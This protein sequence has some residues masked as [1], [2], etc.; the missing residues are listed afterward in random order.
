MNPLRRLTMLGGMALLGGQAIGEGATH[1]V[2]SPRATTRAASRH[3]QVQHRLQ[4][5]LAHPAF[6]GHAHLLMPGGGVSYDEAMPLR[7]IGDLLPYHTNVRPPEVVDALNRM[8][9]NVA[10]G[11]VVFHDIYT[12]ADKQRDPARGKTGLF[13]FRGKPGAPFAVVAPGGG[14][15]YV[16]SVHEGF[17]YAME[18]SNKGYNAFVLVYR[19][20]QGGAVAT[21]DL[22]AALSFI[23]RNA[24]RLGVNTRAYSLWGSSAGARMAAAIGTHGAAAFGGDLLPK[25]AAVVMAYTGHDEFSPQDPPTFALVGENDR[26]APPEVME[27]R[28][29]ALRNAGVNVA[30]R[31]YPGVAH[32][33]GR[34]TGTSAS[35]WVGDAIGFWERNQGR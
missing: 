34:G 19:V 22:A 30:W 8:I 31:R 15:S 5:L 10:A 28:V 35:G 11:Q 26:I 4:D 9:D 1:A 29:N 2:S 13:L 20:G 7:D 23:F 12:A 6:A 18:I 32:G 16:G 14:F 27:R 17:P 3:I 24:D 25:P 21:Q 33:F